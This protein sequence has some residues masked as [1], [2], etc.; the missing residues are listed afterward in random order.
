[1]KKSIGCYQPSGGLCG[2]A[3]CRFSGIPVGCRWNEVV[4]KGWRRKTEMLE[5]DV[6]IIWLVMF[7]LRK[8]SW[9]KI[10]RTFL[11]VE[12]SRSR[13]IFMF[14]P[15]GLGSQVLWRRTRRLKPWRNWRRLR[16]GVKRPKVKLKPKRCL[17]HHGMT[18][19]LEWKNRL[20]LI[21][22]HILVPMIWT[23]EYLWLKIHWSCIAWSNNGLLLNE[24]QAL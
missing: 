8:F 6:F 11:K 22:T 24:L 9:K 3:L 2:L 10:Y 21:T 16:P 14:Q 23:D 7:F 13:N 20:C 18:T 5:Y 15:S 19:N 1:M 4:A 17:C 12:F